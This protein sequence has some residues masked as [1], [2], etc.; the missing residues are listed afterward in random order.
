MKKLWLF[1]IEDNP[2]HEA[3]EEEIAREGDERGLWTGNDGVQYFVD[4][5]TPDSD[6]D[7]WREEWRQEIAREEGML[8]GVQAYNDWMGY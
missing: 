1:D 3:T 4:W 8:G 5:Y 2:I 6:D 7:N